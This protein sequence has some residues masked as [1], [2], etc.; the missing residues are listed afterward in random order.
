MASSTPP[1]LFRMHGRGGGSRLAVCRLDLREFPAG[2]IPL[3]QAEKTI[4]VDCSR[5]M[6]Q[7]GI[8]IVQDERPLRL[9]NDPIRPRN[10]GRARII[11]IDSFVLESLPIFDA[12]RKTLVCPPYIPPCVRILR[13]TPTARTPCHHRRQAK[14]RERSP[15]LKR[16][17]RVH[18]ISSRAFF[19]KTRG[20]LARGEKGRA[21]R[22]G[23]E[24]REGRAGRRGG[25]G[26]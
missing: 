15:Q 1:R 10:D 3:R 12:E 11:V 19:C 16:K 4:A 17:L 5:K 2:L 25:E 26:E 9:R 14:K 20:N 21:G 6:S 7:E 18:D 24:G 23:R 8:D 22:A 13:C